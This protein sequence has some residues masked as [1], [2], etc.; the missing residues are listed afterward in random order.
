MVDSPQADNRSADSGG[1]QTAAFDR[2]I[3]CLQHLAHRFIVLG[4]SNVAR[5]QATIVAAA[6]SV[7][8]EPLDLLGAWGHGR[9]YVKDCWVLGRALPA[10]VRCGLWEDLALR[11]RIN[12]NVLLADVGNDLLY[13]AT[14][15]KILACVETCLVRLRPVADRI[16]VCGLPIARILALGP[17]RF[18]AFRSVLYPFSQLQ[19]STAQRWAE[20]ID[21]GLRELAQQPGMHFVEPQSQ[22]YGIDP[23]HITQWQMRAAWR[24]VFSAFADNHSNTL[25]R[26]STAE[27]LYLRI[28]TPHRRRIF[29]WQQ[30]QQQP[31]GHLHDGSVVSLY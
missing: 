20:E 14:P 16:A 28:L 3:D 2:R 25:D 27:G 4:A 1:D 31:A 23:I 19:L 17:L 5:G 21:E 30:R 8:R 18:R 9:G 24:E 10:I 15:D 13:G 7:W 29:G 26:A 6:R 11:E 12:T 22:W